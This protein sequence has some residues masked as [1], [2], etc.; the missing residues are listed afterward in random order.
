MPAQR[1]SRILV[2]TIG[3]AADA[4]MRERERVTRRS[5]SEIFIRIVRSVVMLFRLRVYSRVRRAL[6]V[7]SKSKEGLGRTL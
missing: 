2:L 1:G 3:I 6:D 7:E 5:A 4:V